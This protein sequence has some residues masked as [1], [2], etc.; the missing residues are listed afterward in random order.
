MQ[1]FPASNEAEWDSRSASRQPHTKPSTM[2]S[3]VLILCAAL[4]SQAVFA[5]DIRPA[6]TSRGKALAGIMIEGEIE[7]G[8]YVKFTNA[9]IDNPGRN[10][11]VYLYSPGGDFSE[12]LKIGRLIHTLK[13]TTWA[14]LSIEKELPLN[15]V[16][17]PS[18]R[19]C[20]SSCFF[21]FAAGAQRFGE[22]IGIHRPYLPRETY[23]SF[24]ME[25][26]GQAHNEVEE[27][28]KAYLKEIDVPLSYLD[29]IM[30]VDSGEIEWLSQEEVKKQFNDFA[31]AYREWIAAICSPPSDSE[32]S[33]MLGILKSTPLQF[34]NLPI[35]E[36]PYAPPD[37]AF[38]DQYFAKEASYYNCRSSAQEQEVHR[39]WKVMYERRL[40]S[41]EKARS[42]RSQK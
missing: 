3:F 18:N 42:V 30:S 41:Q 27:I 11:S 29:R 17:D 32:T 35:S 24:S 40:K 23:K 5:A 6:K 38:L 14:P 9:F 2:K 21:M 12:A 20:A 26:A 8:D 13:L 39:L 10:G 4:T 34:K 28:V 25:E 37:K 15:E 31:P 22:I 36:V 19:V 1:D 7:K 33:K 16:R